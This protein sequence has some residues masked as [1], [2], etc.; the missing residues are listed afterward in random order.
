MQNGIPAKYEKRLAEETEVVEKQELG[1][2]QV[3]YGG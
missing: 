1:R 2:L 3:K